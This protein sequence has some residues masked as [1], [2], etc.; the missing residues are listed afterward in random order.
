MQDHC[1]GS[2]GQEALSSGHPGP[3][4]DPHRPKGERG[5]EAQVQAMDMQIKP[6]AFTLQET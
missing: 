4:P 3:G 5:P 1:L 6:A 2:R